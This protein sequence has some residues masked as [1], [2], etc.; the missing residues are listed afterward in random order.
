MI[1]MAVPQK[2]LT[3]GKLIEKLRSFSPA[4]DDLLVWTEGCDCDGKAID[5]KRIAPEGEENAGHFLI[6]RD[7]V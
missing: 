6:R 4:D 7:D 5:V 2:Q 1:D 3:L